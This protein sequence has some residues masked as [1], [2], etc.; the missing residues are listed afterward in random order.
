MNHGHALSVPIADIMAGAPMVYNAE[1]TAGHAHYVEL[2]AEDFTSLQNGGTV[3][4]VS[5][6]GGDHEFVLSCGMPSVMPG[7]P[8]CAMNDNCGS[9]MNT[10]CPDP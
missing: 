9:D 6:N 1:G 10:L 7:N 5:C 3:R 4:K 2:T 8:M